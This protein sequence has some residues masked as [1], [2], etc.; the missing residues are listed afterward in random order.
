MEEDQEAAG[1]EFRGRLMEPNLVDLSIYA[2][3]PTGLTL[4]T[5]IRKKR[6]GS[7][8]C[9]LLPGAESCSQDWSPTIEYLRRMSKL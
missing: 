8:C 1:N 5:P 2:Q 9:A 4:W 3:R 7:L 6:C